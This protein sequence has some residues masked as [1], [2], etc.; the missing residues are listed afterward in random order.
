MWRRI[1]MSLLV[2]AMTLGLV[3]VHGFAAGS[4]GLQTVTLHID[5]MTCGGCVKGVR[6]A[7]VKVPGVSAVELTMGTTWLFFS[8]YADTRASV[9]FDPE[10]VGVEA[11]IKVVEAASSPLSTYKARLLEK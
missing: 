1:L 5:G 4:Q 10:K 2:G 7:F 9:T 11:L 3:G 8:D 6:A